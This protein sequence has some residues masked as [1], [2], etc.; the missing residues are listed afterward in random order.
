MPRVFGEHDGDRKRASYSF[1][2]RINDDR[3]GGTLCRTPNE[4]EV[5]FFGSRSYTV[6]VTFE[7]YRYEFERKYNARY[8]NTRTGR[9]RAY[10]YYITRIVDAVGGWG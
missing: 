5:R 10:R 7:M 9:C 3:V 6:S 4:T 8:G 1:V 2:F